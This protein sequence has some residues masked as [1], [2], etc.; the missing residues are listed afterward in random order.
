MLKVYDMS[1]AL[2]T[3]ILL[4]SVGK[5]VRNDQNNYL[6]EIIE[7]TRSATD[8]T[9]EYAILKSDQL[10]DQE[11]R[12]FAIP[13]SSS[14]IKITEAGEI[15][16]LTSKDELHHANGIMQEQCPRPDFQVKPTIFELIEYNGPIIKDKK[17]KT[18]AL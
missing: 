18:E 12:Y 16:L 10:F 2:T 11:E 9:I 8:A 5:R 3:D 6:G 4:Q 13:A 17:A 15:I 1:L 14:L 7:I